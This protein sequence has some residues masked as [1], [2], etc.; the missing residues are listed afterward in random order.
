MLLF[1]V[2]GGEVFQEQVN[3][4]AKQCAVC[5]AAFTAKPNVIVRKKFCC[6]HCAVRGGSMARSDKRSKN[7]GSSRSCVQCGCAFCP[8]RSDV[9]YCSKRCANRYKFEQGYIRIGN[10][11][12]TCSTCLTRI[13][14]SNGDIRARLDI[15]DEAIAV[16]RRKIPDPL[17][18]TG[19]CAT[20]ATPI[21]VRQHGEGGSR[22][23]FCGKACMNKA[24]SGSA[25][26]GMK[27]SYLLNLITKR[28]CLT[29]GDVPAS[30]IDLKRAQVQLKRL[31]K[32]IKHQKT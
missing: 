3:V 27:N 16:Q 8:K 18:E 30:L 15:T 17:V 2:G 22:R 19:V 11:P 29:T 23:M 10:R 6:Y 14:M 24:H 28:S 31:C 26:S 20:C 7:R 9:K 12:R 5:G 32:Q 25:I 13:G 21:I 1:S 4:S